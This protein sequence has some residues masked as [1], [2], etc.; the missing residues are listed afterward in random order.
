[1]KKL[2]SILALL[3]ALSVLFAACND[4]PP[5]GDQND[6]NQSAQNPPAQNPPAQDPPA[7]DPPAQDPP[8]QDP[9][10]QDPPAQDPPAQDPPAQDPPP[11]IIFDE[12]PVHE[13]VLYLLRYEPREDE[14]ISSYTST[15][16]FSFSG[17]AFG[18]GLSA[19]A[20]AT[21]KACRPG[22]DRDLFYHQATETTITMSMSGQTQTMTQH[23]QNGYADGKM[24]SSYRDDT[25]SD[26]FA[27]FSHLTAEEYL[28][29]LRRTE[30]AAITQLEADDCAQMTCTKT[31]N[32]YEAALSG[33]TAAGLK[34]LSALWE[35]F[36][37]LL[38]AEVTDVRFTFAVNEMLLP[39]S[40]QLELIFAEDAPTTQL[41]ISAIYHDYNETQP[42]PIDLSDYLVITDL[43][44][45]DMIDKA[46]SD[47]EK[48]ETLSFDLVANLVLAGYDT[49]NQTSHVRITQDGF[50]VSETIDGSPRTT[51]YANGVITQTVNG[52]TQRVNATPDEAHAWVLSYVKPV[53]PKLATILDASVHSG[54]YELL[55][56]P[57]DTTQ[58]LQM[59][60]PLGVEEEDI[61]ANATLKVKLNDDGSLRSLDYLIEAQIIIG[62][63]TYDAT[64]RIQCNNYDFS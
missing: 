27:L 62:G 3:L 35:S 43:R 4:T 20:H 55:I 21:L 1:M 40:M 32:G 57:A 54:T 29:H 58:L 23:T 6:K 26:S 49:S 52:H 46:L 19:S 2:I 50:T 30:D 25:G 10:A 34:K 45:A 53:A 51:Q 33:F 63:M 37:S 59:F 18:I 8:A 44:V 41:Q 9:P 64:Y 7:Q 17:S 36:G 60:G 61:T 24:F 48:A 38:D 13:Q 47:A 12:L 14:E 31:A 22:T 5:T 56:S 16:T 42:T 39:V 11:E 15:M 28:E